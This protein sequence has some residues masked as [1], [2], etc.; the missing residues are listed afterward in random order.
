[1]N[2]NKIKETQLLI[3]C[4]NAYIK[5]DN[6]ARI[7]LKKSIENVFVD[8]NSIGDLFSQFLIN[9]KR[10]EQNNDVLKQVVKLLQEII[11]DNK[12]DVNAKK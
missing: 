11:Q 5:Y 8:K 4:L 6:D 7:Y 9:N 3:D 1:M 12:E 10:Y 2:E